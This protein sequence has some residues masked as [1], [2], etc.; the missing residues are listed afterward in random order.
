MHHTFLTFRSHIVD[1]HFVQTI[2]PQTI[3][4]ALRFF[5]RRSRRWLRSGSGPMISRTRLSRLHLMSSSTDSTSS[6]QTGFR[7]ETGYTVNSLMVIA[8]FLLHHVDRACCHVINTHVLT[9]EAQELFCTAYDDDLMFFSPKWTS[10]HH[11]SGNANRTCTVDNI[12]AYSTSSTT[13]VYHYML[14]G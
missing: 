3:P 8:H 2:L 7:K 5:P 6:V 9:T 10:P 13:L 11:R 12:T 4:S 1:E 14:F